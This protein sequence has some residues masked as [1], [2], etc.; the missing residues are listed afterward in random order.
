MNQ[1]IEESAAKHTGREEA[2]MPIELLLLGGL[3][4]AVASFAILLIRRFELTAQLYDH[5]LQ[6]LGRLDRD[7]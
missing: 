3:L 1:P 2:E 4:I 7:R 6:P 5:P